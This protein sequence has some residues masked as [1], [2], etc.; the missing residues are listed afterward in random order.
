MF[1]FVYYI[2][3]G[4]GVGVGIGVSVGGGVSVVGAGGD[5]HSLEGF[6]VCFCVQVG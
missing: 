3:A 1:A 6:L 2:P 4:I 5:S